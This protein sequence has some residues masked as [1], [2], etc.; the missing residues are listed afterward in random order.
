MSYRLHWEDTI[1][2][3]EYYGR[4][5]N[6]DILDSNEEVYQ[7]EQ[8]AGMTGQLVNMLGVEEIA[9]DRA[10]MLEIAK[11]DK[12]AAE[13]NPDVK[14]ALIIQKVLL[15][16]LSKLYEFSTVN[17]PWQIEMF[18]SKDEAEHWLNSPR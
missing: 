16:G 15:F 17:S 6:D 12:I 2:V 8:F 7:S 13:K 10:C 18:Y 9:V 11:R 1:A 4:F 14:V 5:T 3:F